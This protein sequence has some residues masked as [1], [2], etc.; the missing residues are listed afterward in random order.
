MPVV[1]RQGSM[2]AKGLG[3]TGS[4]GP[5]SGSQSYTTA[6]TYTW[7]APA[8]VTKVSVVAVGGGGSGARGFN[9]CGNLFAGT[10]GA[11]GG[12]GYKNNL[13][14]TPGNSYTVVVGAGSNQSVVPG[15]TSYFNTAGL[16]SGVGGFS[17][18]C[19]A[20][21]SNATGGTYTGD[22]GGNGG[23]GIAGNY[24]FPPPGG[25]G[26][27][28]YGGAGGD[29]GSSWTGLNG[30]PGACGAG[31]GAAASNFGTQPAGGGGGVGIFGRGTSGASQPTRSLGGFGGSCG[32]NGANIG[33]GGAYGGGGGGSWVGACR[34]TGGRGAVRIV[35]P[36]NLRQ[37]PTTCV[38]LP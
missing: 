17:Q 18:G 37:F 32:C 33:T 22:G 1:S 2:A 12:L 36:G 38:G 20:I 11:G 14:V 23:N 27:G 31:G 25:G 4:T 26:A 10:S 29:G 3:F 5:Q 15:G 16:V 30:K 21:T 24:Y 35:W 28:G 19:F 7:V 9:C 6:G 34:T 8:G 13:T